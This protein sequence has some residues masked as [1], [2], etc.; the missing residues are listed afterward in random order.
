MSSSD[1]FALQRSGLNN[2]LFAIVGTE[3][4]GMDLSLVS[5]FARQG[6]DPWREAGRLAGLPKSEAI[7]S[8]ARILAAMPT[9]L[10]PLPAA[11][12]IATRL[13]GLLPMPGS[14]ASGAPAIPAQMQRF[15]RI[16]MLLAAV[17]FGA[18]YAAGAFTTGIAPKPGGDA[19]LS[20]PAV[21]PVS[22]L[23][24]HGV[25]KSAPPAK[26]Q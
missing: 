24:A 10:W 12:T 20:T 5:V 18:A 14:I 8:L 23:A 11:T 13:I 4:N 16:G 3:P 25:V 9:S 22:P 26:G 6:N 15:A 7:D 19:A 2:F 17:A 1:A 21:A